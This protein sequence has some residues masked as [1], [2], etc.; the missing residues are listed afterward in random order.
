MHRRHDDD[1]ISPLAGGNTFSYL[2]AMRV[3]GVIVRMF[4]KPT[5]LQWVFMSVLEFLSIV[6]RG[7]M[8][9]REALA[10]VATQC[11]QLYVFYYCGDF[12][13]E[14]L[15]TFMCVTWLYFYSR[16]LTLNR[17]LLSASNRDAWGIFLFLS[18]WLCRDK[19]RSNVK[20]KR[21]VHGGTVIWPIDFIAT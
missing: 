17:A 15:V 7:T 2:F 6:R 13:E 10:Y 9:F 19:E 3:K 20:Y 5:W 1:G 12:D 14:C 4:N 11:R 8:N 21:N 16:I 18:Y